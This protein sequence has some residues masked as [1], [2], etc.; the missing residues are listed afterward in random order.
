TVLVHRT[1]IKKTHKLFKECDF[2]CLVSKNLYNTCLY[3]IRQFGFLQENHN[4]VVSPEVKLEREQKLNNKD[5]EKSLFINQDFFLG[6]ENYTNKNGEDKL[7]KSYAFQQTPLYHCV[8][9]LPE[10]RTK[11]HPD[12]KNREINTKI[13]KQTIKQVEHDLSNFLKVLKAYKRNPENCLGQPKIPNYKKKG[14][15]GRMV[16]TVPYGAISINPKK[17]ILK[18]G[19][20][21]I[22]LDLS[23]LKD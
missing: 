7:K 4:F 5:K 3:Q 16:V 6:S 22:C 20:T 9:S 12:Y 11:K 15:L 10:F 14:N 21:D 23:K 18:F 17:N 8:K 19:M 13:L 2:L 1:H